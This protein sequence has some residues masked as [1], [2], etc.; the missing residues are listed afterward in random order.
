MIGRIQE[1]KFSQN[2]AS[3]PLS[4]SQD[5]VE[6]GTIN[7]IY[8]SATVTIIETIT[9]TRVSR[10]GAQYN[11]LLK[12]VNLNNEQYYVYH[13]ESNIVIKKGD[14]IKVQCTNANILGT[15]NG[16]IHFEGGVNE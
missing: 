5:Y 2:L 13:P 10:H 11:C 7:A 3:A 6:D 15:M 9:I 16:I 4:V 1:Q 14:S 8:F 12:T